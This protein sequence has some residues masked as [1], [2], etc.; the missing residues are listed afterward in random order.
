MSHTL[1]VANLSDYYYSFLRKLSKES[2]IDLIAKLAK[3]LNE[4]EEES[5]EDDIV[6]VESFFEAF[7]SDITA[8][9]ILQEI[10]ALKEARLLKRGPNDAGS[11]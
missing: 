11:F 10:K 3:S 1:K 9:E 7:K 5:G 4:D 6:T 2:K 8:Q